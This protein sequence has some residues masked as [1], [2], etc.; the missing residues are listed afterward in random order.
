MDW[1]P[2]TFIV[3]E[4]LTSFKIGAEY[5]LA[6]LYAVAALALYRTGLRHRDE[7]LKALAMAAW[8]L[9]LAEMFFTLYSDVTDIFN[10]LGHIYKAIAYL[11]I[12]R[13]LFRDGVKSPYLQLDRERSQLDVLIHSIPDLVWLKSAEGVYL[14]CNPAFERFF[15]APESAIVGK[16]DYDF[17]SRRTSRFFPRERSGHVAGQRQCAKRRMDYLRGRWQSMVCLKPARFRFMPATGV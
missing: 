16:T 12:Y 17:V 3:G 11:I 10:L 1:L 15:G 4:G 7:N 9:G 2:R 6:A 5:L 13:A 14:R 8:I